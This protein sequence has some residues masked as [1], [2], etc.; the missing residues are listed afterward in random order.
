MPP[1]ILP[2][3]GRWPRGLAAAPRRWSPGAPR[4]FLPAKLEAA[5]LNFILLVRFT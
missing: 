5:T 4:S 1:R 2:A 3:A